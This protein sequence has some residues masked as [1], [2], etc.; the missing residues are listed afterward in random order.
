VHEVGAIP[1]EILLFW[2]I[3]AHLMEIS[4]TLW[5][6]GLG[7]GFLGVRVLGVWALDAVWVIRVSENPGF[8]ESGVWVPGNLWFRAGIPAFLHWVG[9]KC[10]KWALF[11]LESFFFG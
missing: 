1:P 6:R 7:L 11:A 10:M 3:I 9:D 2:V 8:W 4:P 5:L